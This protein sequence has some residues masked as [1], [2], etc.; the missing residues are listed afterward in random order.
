MEKNRNFLKSIGLC[1]LSGVMTSISFSFENLWF[2]CFFSLMPMFFAFRFYIRKLNCRQSAVSFFVYGFSLYSTLMLW[3]L[4]LSPVLEEEM[5]KSAAYA[6]IML[7]I[8]LSALFLGIYYSLALIFARVF[9]KGPLVDCAVFDFLYILGEFFTGLFNPLSF[10]WARLCVIATPFTAFIQ[11][12]SLFGG[13]F[14]SLIIV[15]FNC[16]FCLALCSC[17]SP[18]KCIA[19]VSAALLLIGANTLYGVIRL[20]NAEKPTDECNAVIVQGNF[21]GLS[22][23]RSSREEIISTYI[24]L[25]EEKIDENTEFVVFPETAVPFRLYQD[26]AS[27]LMLTDFA[28]RNNIVLVTGVFYEEEG[29]VYNSLVCI[30]PDGKISE[31]YHKQVLV[32]LGEY[33]PFADFLMKRWPELF[34]I[35]GY[36]KAGDGHG[37]VSTSR[38]IIGGVICYES[39]YPNIVRQ[40]VVKG[41]QVITLI[42][43]DSWFG[44]SPALYQ[45]HAHAR[46]RAVENNRYV[47]R[48]SSTAISSAIDNHGRI[49]VTAPEL[50]SAAVKASYQMI[51]EKTLYTTVG[52][53]VLIPSLIIVFYALYL[54]V[55]RRKSCEKSD[56]E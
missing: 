52:D 19:Y 44:E 13:L 39:I 24:S 45:H 55:K 9:S 29:D 30:E 8:V 51:P 34:E 42:S 27:L 22:K 28:S 15:L 26:E 43:N 53:I 38:G 46:L 31:P 21:S 12:A 35:I 14:V 11:S 17:R 2:L 1:A 37:A 16:I 33:V 50:K 10:P 18:K 40:S 54:I 47:L 5:P 36:V 6:L 25:A 49:I 32:P 4:E 48:A 3:L 20:E 56:S 41:A 23:W 7:A